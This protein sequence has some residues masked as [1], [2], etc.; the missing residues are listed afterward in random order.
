MNPEDRSARPLHESGANAKGW[1]VVYAALDLAKE[2]FGAQLVAAYALGSLAHD[3][4]A[5][6]V[7]D[8]DVA[9]ILDRLD[10][11]TETRMAEIRVTAQARLGTPLSGRLSLF[12]STWEALGGAGS[13][14][15]FPLM[16][17]QDLAL[18]GVCLRGT[19]RRAEV[20]LPDELAMRR[21][22]IVESAEFMLA[23]L[24][25]PEREELLQAPRRLISLGCRE[26]TKAVLFP[27]RF[28]YTLETGSA[29]NN[30]KAVEWFVPRANGPVAALADAA[31]EWRH[32]GTLGP[33]EL[34]TRTLD[35][36]LMPLYSMLAA[37]YAD[38]LR[39]LGETEL[40]AGL[41]AWQERLAIRRDTRLDDP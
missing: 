39:E 28:L 18:Y 22:L 36:G 38:A 27:V 8:V 14:G 10:E 3:G 1:G 7:S 35:A 5:P 33:E 13:F 12:W 32:R 21:E 26:V 6:D 34:T 24:A 9:L 25:L 31:L 41:D 19:D 30:P 2:A 16:D 40:S 29:A 23:K 37:R 11:G 20:V 4:F 17:R 15:R